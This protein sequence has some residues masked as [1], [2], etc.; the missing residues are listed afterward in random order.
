MTFRK[1]KATQ[2]FTGK[3]MLGP[4]QVLIVGEDGSVTDIVSEN[5]AGDN[6]QSFPGILS[7]GFVN[8]HCHLELSHMRGLIPEK[9]GLVDFILK[10]LT[11]RHFPDDAIEK[12]IEKAEAEMVANGIVAVGDISNNL[13]TLPQKLKKNIAYYTFVEVSGWNPGLAQSR[14]E[15]SKIDYE[16]FR[17]AA[18][19]A[20]ISMVPHAP[21]SVSPDLWQLMQP[22]FHQHTI[23]IHN[24]ET[25]F[26]NDFFINGTGDFNR[27]YQLLNIDTSFYQP[28]GLGSIPYYLPKMK[29]AKNVLLVHDTFTSE[30]D[31]QF[32]Q[33]QSSSGLQQ[34][35]YCLCVNANQYIENA[36]PP[37][38][39]FRK[40]NTTL[41]IGTDS[42][43]S[44]HSLSILDEIKTIAKNF[45]QIPLEEI[46]QWA[47]FNGARALQMDDLLGS[48]EK[49]K[50]PG[51]LVIEGGIHTENAKV[52]RLL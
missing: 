52:K 7:P 2:L 44:N 19:K 3:K 1:F 35:F 32:V 33:R 20:K 36:L 38:E 29:D 30:A 31:V 9:T 21:Y 48:F 23:S 24:Q 47:T 14:F 28:P 17:L 27:L 41:V 39:L 22:Y 13:S 42:L 15:K 11:E 8:S 34:F 46:L 4:E 5:E 51:V 50:K 37:I 16:A 49:G 10:I 45:P 40:N 18:P 26:E 43:A 6:I 12:A 25:V